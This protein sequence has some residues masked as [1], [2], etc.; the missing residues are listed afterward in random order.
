ME[1]TPTSNTIKKILDFE[2][3]VSDMTQYDPLA[4]AQWQSANGW[5]GR[6]YWVQN[7]SQATVLIQFTVS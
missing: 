4:E 7:W 3:D 6:I 2:E 5:N 1:I